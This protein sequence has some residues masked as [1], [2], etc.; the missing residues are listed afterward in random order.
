MI[1][2]DIQNQLQLLIKVSAPPLIEVSETQLKLPELVPGQRLSAIV[3][4]NLPNGRFQV[5]IGD[6]VLDLNLPKNTQAGDKLDLTFVSN[7]PRLTF[8]LSR[9]LP[10][11]GFNTA[12]QPQVS[13]SDSA[14]FLGALLQKVAE[15][16]QSQTSPL[17]KFAPLMTGAPENT[18]VLADTLHNTISKSGMFYESHQAQWVTGQRPLTDLTMEPQGKLSGLGQNAQS[19][20][21]TAAGALAQ[22]QN[23]VHPQTA[24]IVQQQLDILDSRQIIWQGQV[25]PGQAMD[26]RIEEDTHKEQGQD[27]APAWQTRLYLKMPVLGEV[28]ATLA[29][30]REGI[31]L[32][33][34][35]SDAE[36]ANKLKANQPTLQSALQTAGINLLGLKVDRNEEA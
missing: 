12:G 25:W 3:L 23:A 6:S 7:Q 30:N 18:K 24:P 14:K 19:L 22:T 36:T 31:R 28:E 17:T 33:I 9:D 11:A 13:I 1:Y 26:W 29:L 34:N 35:V 15:Q 8:A 16:A 2:N 10:A 21:G 27:E 20:S 4:G 32:S 5:L